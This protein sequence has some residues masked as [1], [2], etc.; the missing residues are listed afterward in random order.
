MKTYTITPHG[1]PDQK[2]TVQALRPDTAMEKYAV[3]NRP[4]WAVGTRVD[5]KYPNY[6]VKYSGNGCLSKDLYRVEEK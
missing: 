4:S 2:A 3:K 5:G 6:Q 1:K